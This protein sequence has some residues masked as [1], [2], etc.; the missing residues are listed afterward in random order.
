[1][2]K[3]AAKRFKREHRKAKEDGSWYCAGC[4]QRHPEGMRCPT[5]RLK[6]NGFNRVPAK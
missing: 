1:M 5:P 3:R 6:A 4:Q 2:D